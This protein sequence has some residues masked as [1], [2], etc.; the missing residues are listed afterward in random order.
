MV[1]KKKQ[2]Y[3]LKSICIID[4]PKNRKLL[5]HIVKSVNMWADRK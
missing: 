1:V 4:T 2:E 3:L 5:K